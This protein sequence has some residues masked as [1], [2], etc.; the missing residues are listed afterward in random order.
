M[1]RSWSEVSGVP[2]IM[3][4][5]AGYP[6]IPAEKASKLTGKEVKITGPYTYKRK[7]GNEEHEKTIVGHPKE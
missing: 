5:K 4:K 7:I 2:L 1:K 6:Q 3:A